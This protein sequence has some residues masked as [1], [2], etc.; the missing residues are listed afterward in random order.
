MIPTYS[1][2]EIIILES[3]IHFM[4]VTMINFIFQLEVCFLGEVSVLTGEEKADHSLK[5]GWALS[6]LLKV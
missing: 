1:K 4:I 6:D 3:L 5:C 2:I